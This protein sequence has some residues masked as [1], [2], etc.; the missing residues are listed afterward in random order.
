MLVK[1]LQRESTNR[2]HRH[3]YFIYM[4]M[5]ICVHMEMYVCTYIQNIHLTVYICAY[6]LLQRSASCDCGG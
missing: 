4:Y 5:S 6:D 1:V 2:R 3:M